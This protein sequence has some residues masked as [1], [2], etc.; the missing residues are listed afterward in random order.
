MCNVATVLIREGT[1]PLE[2]VAGDLVAF[3]YSAS[4]LFF[5]FSISA[6]FIFSLFRFSANTFLSLPFHP[7]CYDTE[8]VFTVGDGEMNGGVSALKT[9]SKWTFTLPPYFHCKF[10]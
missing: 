2:L 4:W 3:I 7:D 5:R 6:E 9:K 8:V 1:L 10:L